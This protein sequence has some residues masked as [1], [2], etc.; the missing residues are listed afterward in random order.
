MRRPI[1]GSSRGVA[2]GGSGGRSTSY[3]V[4]AIGVSSR[5]VWAAR[6]ASVLFSLGAIPRTALYSAPSVPSDLRQSSCGF[7][8]RDERAARVANLLQRRIQRGQFPGQRSA[9]IGLAGDQRRW[10]LVALGVGQID[11]VQ[12]EVEEAF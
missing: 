10:D 5:E 4:E 2:S 1:S 6:R 7:L 12:F 9:Q 11:A 8:Q 3:A